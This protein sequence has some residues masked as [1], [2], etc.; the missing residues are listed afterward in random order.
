M[1]VY[2]HTVLKS[3]EVYENWSKHTGAS[4]VVLHVSVQDKNKG[5]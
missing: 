2:V 5:E 3:P 4:P 1:Y